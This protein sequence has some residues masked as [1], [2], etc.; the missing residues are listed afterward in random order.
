MAE[1]TPAQKQAA[2]TVT[3]QLASANNA[4][5]PEEIKRNIIKLMEENPQTYPNLKILRQELNIIG[6]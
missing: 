1:L 3:R 6:T 2:T 4:P 5:P